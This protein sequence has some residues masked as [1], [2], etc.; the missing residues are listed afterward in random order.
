MKSRLL[1][2]AVALVLVGGGVFWWFTSRPASYCDQ[3]VA[4]TNAVQAG[5]GV[6]Q[7]LVA[8]LPELRDLAAA[9][10]SDLTDEWQVVINAVDGMRQAFADTGVDPNTPDLA[11]LPPSVTPAQKERLQSAAAVLVSAEVTQ[12]VKGIQQEALDVC[13]TP[14]EL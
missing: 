4:R 7:N 9:A 1:V 14:M 6:M 2:A 10:P 5:Q 8:G 11:A 12:A 13:H 3:I